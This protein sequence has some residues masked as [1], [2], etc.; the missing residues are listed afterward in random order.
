[1][2]VIGQRTAVAI[3]VLLATL[4][5]GA[6]IFSQLGGQAASVAGNDTAAKSFVSAATST[7]WS[8]LRMVEIGAIVM[9][10]VFVLGLLGLLG[11]STR[12]EEV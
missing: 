9:G 2:A 6:I 7:G 12:G 8:A 3:I 1:M 4:M 10:A 5:I 11:G